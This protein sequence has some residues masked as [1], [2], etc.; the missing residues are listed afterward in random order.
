MKFRYSALGVLA[1]LASVVAAGA[2][3]LNGP[4]WGVQQVPYY[5]NPANPNMSESAALAAIQA[6]AA[7]WSMQSNANILPY[8]M[9][10]TSGNRISKNG[11]SEV[12]FRNASNGSLY[13]ETYWWY[14][15]SYRLIEADIVF[16]SANYRFFP[17][18]SGCSGSGLYLQDATAHE[19]GHVLG[20][21]HSSLKGATMYPSMKY[22]STG[23]R[24][25]DSDD[26]AGIEKLYPAGAAVNT[27]PTVTITAPSSGATFTQGT[28]ITLSGSANDNEDGNITSSLSWTSSI[29]GALGIGGSVTRALSAG[30]HA[31]TAR[32]TDS[33]GIST[34]RQISVSVTATPTSPT[35]PQSGGITLTATG[36]KSTD[37]LY[38]DL[39]WSGASSTN[40]D[41]FRDGSRILTT[42]NDGKQT[43]I[44]GGTSGS[45]TY[46]ICEAA[47]SNCSNSVA[48][49]F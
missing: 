24:S 34:S 36:R 41:I 13:G 31:I 10:R 44:K 32:V 27:A 40:V 39:T 6:G 22:C 9:G 25:L 11:R 33:R 1:L 35:P 37:R 15:G 46:K 20:L 7:G 23:A 4:K 42:V 16:Y 30:S 5:I 48:V 19:F 8:Y 18:G 17:G 29:D 38:I 28:S 21:G 26:L 43:D 45:F 49:N 3:K 12:F 47:T 2:Y 14:D